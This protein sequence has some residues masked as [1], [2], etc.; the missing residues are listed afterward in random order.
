MGVPLV[1]LAGDWLGG[2][3][4]ASILEGFGRPDWIAHSEDEYVSIVCNLARDVEYRKQLRKDQRALM[5]KSELCDAKGLAR[6]LE[7]AFEAMYDEWC[8]G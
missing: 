6:C 3:M 8:S 5:A 2:S 4:A 1:T 7:D